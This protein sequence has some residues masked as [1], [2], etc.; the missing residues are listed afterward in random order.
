MDAVVC[1]TLTNGL[2]LTEHAQ[3]GQVSSL[4]F[5]SRC[6]LCSFSLSCFSR[7]LRSSGNLFANLANLGISCALCIIN[8]CDEFYGS[9]P[10]SWEL[11]C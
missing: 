2:L 5:F 3:Y 6:R 8:V 4:F 9:C 7:L 10:F 11:R 1:P